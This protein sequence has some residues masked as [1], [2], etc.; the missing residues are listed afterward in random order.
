MLFK[1]QCI[2]TDTDSQCRRRWMIS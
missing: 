1:N 2:H